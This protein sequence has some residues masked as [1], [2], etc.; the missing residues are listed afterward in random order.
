MSGLV[1]AAVA[2]VA[3]VVLSSCG[4][5]ATPGAASGHYTGRDGVMGAVVDFR[6]SDPTVTRIRAAIGDEQVRIVSAYIVNRSDAPILIPA[7]S[8]ERFDGRVSTLTRA[9]ADPLVRRTG[10]R[11]PISIPA[12]GAVTVYLLTR[13]RPEAVTAIVMRRRGGAVLSLEPQDV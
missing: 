5:E 12:R 4:G 7:V 9:D 8:A 10:L 11:L 3:A 6:A 13:E 1:R 2:L